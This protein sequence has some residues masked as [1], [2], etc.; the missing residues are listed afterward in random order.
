[1]SELRG[2]SWDG[3]VLSF[4]E[5]TLLPGRE[6]VVRTTDWRVIVDAIKRLAI[7]G[8]PAIGVAGAFASLLAWRELNGDRASW[9]KA[10]ATIEQAR[11]TAVNLSWAVKR[12]RAVAGDASDTDAEAAL[13]AEAEAIA[14]RDEEMCEAM[15]KHGQSLIPE[16][17]SALTHCNTGALVTYG[18]GTALG[19]LRRAHESGRLNRVY[20]CEARPLGQGSRLTIWE[21]NRLN[22]P[23]TLLTDSAA[24]RLMQEGLVDFL[25]V[26]ADRIAANGDTANKVGTFNLA[27]LAKR[28]EIPFYVV[29]PSSTFDPSTPSGQDV[30][31]ELRDADE[32]RT[33]AGQLVSIPEADV[34][35]PAFDI[36]PGEL[37][38][39]FVSEEGILLPPYN[40]RE[41]AALTPSGE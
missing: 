16:N 24:G 7:R 8:A 39:A 36:T 30:P 33:C 10:L 28:F 26:G 32:V 21:L 1:M 35:N 9:D 20:A 31:V 34:F 17:A 18:I 41:L 37:I 23:A 22:I 11:P 15:A 13:L 29:A 14:I 2:L 5:Q 3:T 27:A 6:E 12:M 40:F 4:L 38:S 25:M 19:V